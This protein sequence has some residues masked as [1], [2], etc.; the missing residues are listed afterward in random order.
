MYVE[1][2]HGTSSYSNDDEFMTKLK[3]LLDGEGAKM[4]DDVCTGA[5]AW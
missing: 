5:F 1:G 2:G 4:T 3:S